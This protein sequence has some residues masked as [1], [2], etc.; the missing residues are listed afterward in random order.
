MMPPVVMPDLLSRRGWLLTA[1][2]S[3]LWPLLGLSCGTT[4]SSDS[5]PASE[6]MPDQSASASS[7]SAD[8]TTSAPRSQTELSMVANDVASYAE[9]HTVAESAVMKAIAEETRRATEWSIM[10]IG[11]LEATLLRMLVRLTTARR[12]VEVGT[13]TGYSAIAMAEGLPDDGRIYTLDISEEWTAIARRHWAKSP[14]GRKIELTLGP[15]ADTLPG[16][17]GPVDLAFV[18][19]DKE[20]YP[21][22]WDLLVPKMRPGGVIVCD[23]VLA[24]GRVVDPNTPRSKSMAAFNDKV[25]ADD[26]VEP[27]MLPIRDGVTLAQVRGG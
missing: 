26:R 4:R 20:S 8:A 25:R 14:H 1:G 10:M 13:F 22:Y 17:A 16:I 11:P 27:L 24:G 9:A 23:N 19:A 18:D 7:S 15:A 2:A 5:S 21:T 12:V 6:P 3:G